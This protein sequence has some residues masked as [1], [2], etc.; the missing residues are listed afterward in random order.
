MGKGN[1]HGGRK[2][3]IKDYK[4]SK[5]RRIAVA[6]RQPADRRLKGQGE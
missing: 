6:N 1:K 2:T 5:H 4:R 3:R